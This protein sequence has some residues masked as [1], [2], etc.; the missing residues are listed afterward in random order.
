MGHNFSIMAIHD[1]ADWAKAGILVLD[2]LKSRLKEMFLLFLLSILIWFSPEGWLVKAGITSVAPVRHTA[3]WLFWATFAYLFVFGGADLLSYL[4]MRR[5]L[6][7]LGEDEKKILQQFIKN[8]SME[9]CFQMYETGTN[10]L[11]KEGFLLPTKVSHVSFAGERP[12]SCYSLKPWV[13]RSLSRNPK[14]IQF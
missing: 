1:P 14:R 11:E 8:N 10:N 7:Y 9:R 12:M 4:Q 6:H 3:V 13:F 2:W 5:R